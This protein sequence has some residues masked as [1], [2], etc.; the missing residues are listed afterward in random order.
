MPFLQQFSPQ[1]LT[2]IASILFILEVIEGAGAID[3][4]SAWTEHGKD[5][6]KDVLLT[7]TAELHIVETPVTNGLFVLAE[8]T[9]S[10]TGDIG[11]EE[12]EL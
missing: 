11:E 12:I 3:E 7:L 8:H 1:E 4:E 2:S 6:L 5:I 9:F 10:R